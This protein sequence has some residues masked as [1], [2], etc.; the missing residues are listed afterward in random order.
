MSDTA[1]GR[2]RYI[3]RVIAD[4]PPL[5]TATAARIRA[6]FNHADTAGGGSE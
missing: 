3:A 1:D 2:A 6:I 5:P 4:A